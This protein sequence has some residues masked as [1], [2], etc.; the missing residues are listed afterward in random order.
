[1]LT[2]DR[3]IRTN[4]AMETA[5]RRRVVALPVD[6]VGLRHEFVRNNLTFPGRR[7]CAQ[8]E[9][10]ASSMLGRTGSTT[11]INA[12]ATPPPRQRRPGPAHATVPGAATFVANRARYGERLSTI[13]AP[14]HH[15]QPARPGARSAHSTEAG[16]HVRGEFRG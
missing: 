12:P 11:H 15:H 13:P 7:S 10:I 4:E 14:L 16:P 1:L 9:A 8:R 6:V 2:R 3:E 5:R